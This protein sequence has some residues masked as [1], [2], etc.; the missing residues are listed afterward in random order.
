ML[1]ADDLLLGHLDEIIDEVAAVL[2]KRDLIESGS[3]DEEVHPQQGLLILFHN[4]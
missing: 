4:I 2:W 3:L 1:H